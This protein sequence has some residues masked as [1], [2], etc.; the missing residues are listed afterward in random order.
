VLT[1]CNDHAQLTQQYSTG[2]LQ[3]AL[4]TMGADEKEYTDCYDVIQRAL[5]ADVGRLHPGTVNSQQPGSSSFLTT[6]LIISISVAAAAA[7][8]VAVLGAGRRRK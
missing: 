3:G 5:L 6:P 8:A 2:D 7:A 4:S 1:D